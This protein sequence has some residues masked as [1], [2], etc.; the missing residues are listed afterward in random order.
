MKEKEGGVGKKN[1]GAIKAE[2]KPIHGKRRKSVKDAS[3][4]KGL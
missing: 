4:R 3:Q 1:R 2:T